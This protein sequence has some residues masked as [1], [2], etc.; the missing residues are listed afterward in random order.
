MNE[1]ASTL[2]ERF[3]AVTTKG[4]PLTVIGPELHEGDLAPE[5]TL[6]ANDQSKVRLSESHGK[7]RLISVV[8]SL[9]TR[10]CDAQTRRFNEEAAALG[11]N[12][13]IITVSAEHPYNQRR[14]C[15]AA[16]IDRVQVLSDHMDMSFGDS[17]GTHIKEWRLEQRAVFVINGE[18]RIVYVEY[19]PEIS[20]H[21][22]YESAL[23]AV[24]KT[25]AVQYLSS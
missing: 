9:D 16:G 5:W 24:R 15:G 1:Q 12:V 6:A 14:W 22:D 2:P 3:A 4:R 11:E 23:D 7:V 25:A 21:P 17:Y 13:V 20:Q 10:I 18:G 19:V 8:P